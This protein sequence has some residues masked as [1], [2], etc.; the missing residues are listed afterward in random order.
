MVERST[1]FTL[2]DSYQWENEVKKKKNLYTQKWN[3]RSY[4]FGHL[5]VSGVVPSVQGDTGQRGSVPAA[6]HQHKVG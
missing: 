2:I 4:L 3:N 5:S 6:E 1:Y